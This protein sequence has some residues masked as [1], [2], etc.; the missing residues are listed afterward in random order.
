MKLV[1]GDPAPDFKALDQ[2]GVSHQLADYRGRWIALFFYPKDNTS[3]CISEACGLRDNF[4]EFT[5]IASI[6]GIS[7]D[8]VSSHKDFA[9]KYFLP[10]TLLADTDRKIVKAYGA[11]R[12]IFIHRTTFLINPDGFISKIYE[13]V[14]PTTHA[15][16]LLN[17]LKKLQKTTL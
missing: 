11:D 16:T 3:G 7:A 8:S 14:S 12:V 2:D 17:D 1:I 9:N 6:L 10:F 13:K 15:T 5:N 4:H